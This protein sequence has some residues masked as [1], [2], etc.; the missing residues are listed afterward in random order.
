MAWVGVLAMPLGW[1]LGY[2]GSK[3]LDFQGGMNGAVDRLFQYQCCRGS[4][5]FCVWGMFR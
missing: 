5:V 2:E 4:L 1:L 3:G